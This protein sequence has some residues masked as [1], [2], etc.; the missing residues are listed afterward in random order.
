MQRSI[1]AF[2]AG[3]VLLS[4]ASCTEARAAQRERSEPEM[5]SSAEWI[6]IGKVEKRDSI[7][8]PRPDVYISSRVTL[9]V[10]AVAHGAPP[11]VVR[12]GIL[13]GVVE[14]QRNIVEDQPIAEVGSRYL[15]LGRLVD[16]PSGSG[17]K[18]RVQL[19]GQTASQKALKLIRFYPLNPDVILPASDELHAIWKEHC[20]PEALK[21][22][23]RRPTQK[24]LKFLPQSIL[25]WCEHY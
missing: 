23:D 24:Y 18:D 13:G 7:Y 8:D 6:F 12:F 1:Q 16:V 25:D 22:Q 15:I 2:L 10:E 11:P 5:C 4:V 17:L 9:R 20:Q 14:S 3:I 19:D 21:G